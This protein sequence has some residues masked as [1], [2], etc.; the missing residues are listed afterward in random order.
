LKRD[1]SPMEIVRLGRDR[2]RRG[3]ILAEAAHRG[4]DRAER[5]RDRAPGPDGQQQRE[6]AD[7]TITIASTVSERRTL[8]LEVANAASPCTRALPRSA[9]RVAEICPIWPFDWMTSRGCPL[10]RARG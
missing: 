7:S 10:R 3:G 4:G 5:P 1:I 8:R 9:A 2:Y 6:H